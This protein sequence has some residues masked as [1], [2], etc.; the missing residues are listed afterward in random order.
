[1]QNPLLSACLLVCMAAIPAHA[2]RAQVRVNCDLP[3]PGQFS[4]ISAA[5][6]A[7]NKEGPSDIVVSGT[8]NE[9]LVINGFKE[10]TVESTTG[11]TVADASGGALSVIQILRSQGVTISGVHVQGGLNGISCELSTQCTLT[12]NTVEN[13]V[14]SGIFVFKHSA[15]TLGGNVVRN[16]GLGMTA[17]SSSF[18]HLLGGGTGSP[19]TI[20]QN[21]QQGLTAF[22]GSSMRVEG[23]ASNPNTI[24]NNHKSGVFLD[25]A[26]ASLFSP[27]I[28]GN[29]NTTSANLGRIEV[30]HSRLRLILG[31][32]TGNAGE[33]IFLADGSHGEIFSSNISNNSRNGVVLVLLSTADFS[34]TNTVAGNTRDDVFCDSTAILRNPARITGTTTVACPNQVAGFG[35]VP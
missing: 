10:L 27:V 23:T 29:G 17:L 33:G 22:E 32:V 1:M 20:E 24:R 6:Q 15:A 14:L 25:S 7:V 18:M 8:C 16:N 30:T 28:T 31:Q 4:S 3:G 26:S 2:Q 34:G 11:A 13:A 9:N 12:N 21:Q 19:N 35:P 5:L